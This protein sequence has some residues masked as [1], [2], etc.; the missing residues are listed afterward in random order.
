M[1]RCTH[2]LLELPMIQDTGSG[3]CHVESSCSKSSLVTGRV[4]LIVCVCMF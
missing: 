2:A 3:N 4:K 1:L